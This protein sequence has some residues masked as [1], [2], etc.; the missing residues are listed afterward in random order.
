MTVHLMLAYVCCAWNL[1]S[2]YSVFI[3]CQRIEALSQVNSDPAASHIVASVNQS[4]AMGAHTVDVHTGQDMNRAG[5]RQG[6][7]AISH[8]TA[9]NK[10]GEFRVKS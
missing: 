3:S 1:Y 8:R 6:W 10:P 9:R 4:E 5:M 7:I 2:A